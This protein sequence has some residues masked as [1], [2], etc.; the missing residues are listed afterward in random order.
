MT[1]SSRLM[2]FFISQIRLTDDAILS[3][4]KHKFACLINCKKMPLSMFNF[5]A[6]FFSGILARVN[7]KPAV[8]ES[9][10]IF[11]N[12]IYQTT[13]LC[14]SFSYQLLTYSGSSLSV[15]L[16]TSSNS[17]IWSLSGYQGKTWQTGQV[18]FIANEDLKVLI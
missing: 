10:W 6:V 8:L 16:V 14:L 4:S 5:Y 1:A 9:P 11:A 2:Y 18:G 15:I 17:T 7:G 13:G 3:M 12:S